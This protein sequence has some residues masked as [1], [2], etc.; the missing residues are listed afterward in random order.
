MKRIHYIVFNAIESFHINCLLLV[1]IKLLSN[2]RQRKSDLISS[3]LPTT[4]I[5]QIPEEPLD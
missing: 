4:E 2:K 5:N 3:Q 1:D